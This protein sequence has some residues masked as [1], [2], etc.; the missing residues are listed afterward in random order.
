MKNP[1]YKPVFNRKKVLNSDGTALVQIQVYLRRQH[2]YF[3]TGIYVKPDQW[4]PADWVINRKDAEDLNRKIRL[5]IHDLEEYEYKAR[6]RGEI[7]ELDMLPDQER[8]K[9]DFLS[10]MAGK[11]QDEDISPA[12]KKHHDITLDHLKDFGKIVYFSDLTR[13]KIEEFDKYLHDLG[14]E[15]STIHGQHK[16]LKKWIRKSI[17]DG[18]LVKDPYLLFKVPMG[19]KGTIKYLSEED[20]VKLEETEINNTRLAAI[21]DVFLFCC[22]TGLA[23]QEA[24]DLTSRNI[25]RD[26]DGTTWITGDR[27]KVRSNKATTATGQFMVPLHKKAVEILTRYKGSRVG[28]SLPVLSNYQYNSMLKEV[29]ILCKIDMHLTTHVAR[30]TFAT[31]FTMARGIS[32]ESVKEML[33]H[34][35][36]RITERYAK[37]LKNRVKE[38]MKKIF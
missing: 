19:N 12:T 22:Y 2:R 14:M 8:E 32:I 17:V 23:Y 31:T 5:V 24:A 6:A 36:V 9:H 27:K 34:S 33:G 1:R 4:D 25:T 29:A 16:R 7:F 3:S 37:V 38:E 21:R 26:E 10:Y 35:S 30:H 11:I 13:K 18:L 20:M 28:Y 15:Q